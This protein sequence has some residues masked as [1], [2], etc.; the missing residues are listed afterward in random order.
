[1]AGFFIDQY[2]FKTFKDS[3]KSKILFLLVLKNP[4]TQQIH[5]IKKPISYRNGPFL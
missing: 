3:A 2:R 5:G 4:G 1:M